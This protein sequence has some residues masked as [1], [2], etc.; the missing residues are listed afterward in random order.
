M[1]TTF[2]CAGVPEVARG[3]ERRA[4]RCE[5]R[6]AVRALVAERAGLVVGF[7]AGRLG[8]ASCV[9]GTTEEVW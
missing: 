1:P 4:G 9:V 7:G 2:A 6:A 8:S 3:A 5:A